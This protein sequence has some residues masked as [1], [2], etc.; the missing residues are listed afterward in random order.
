MCYYF[1]IVQWTDCNLSFYY[2][3][4]EVFFFVWYILDINKIKFRLCFF[5]INCIKIFF[6]FFT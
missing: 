3:F 1:C 4:Q 6:D 5:P 2:I